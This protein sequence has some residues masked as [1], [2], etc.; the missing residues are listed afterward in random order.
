MPTPFLSLPGELRIKIYEIIAVPTTTPHSAY[1]GLYLSCKQIWSEME[2]H[3]PKILAK[4]LQELA[5]TMPVQ[6]VTGFSITHSP[7]Y[8][9]LS[10]VMIQ[11]PLESFYGS[12]PEVF[13]TIDD[14]VTGMRAVY[15]HI[16]PSIDFSAFARLHLESAHLEI[17]SAEHDINVRRA[18]GRRRVIRCLMNMYRRELTSG[19]FKVLFINKVCSERLQTAR[20][21]VRVK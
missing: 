2:Y 1:H 5:R 21:I 10:R 4:Y 14:R 20:T 12:Q 7:I 3:I 18:K 11:M 8:S 17:V 15:T 19:M 16:E 6:G 9:S 13:T